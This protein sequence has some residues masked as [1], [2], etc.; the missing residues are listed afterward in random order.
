MILWNCNDSV[1]PARDARVLW[2]QFTCS[3][4]FRL[5]LIA[6]HITSV[7][8]NNLINKDGF[9]TSAPLWIDQNEVRVFDSDQSHV[10]APSKW[11]TLLDHSAMQTKCQTPLQSYHDVPKQTPLNLEGSK[12]MIPVDLDF[13]AAVFGDACAAAHWLKMSRAGLQVTPTLQLALPN[14]FISPPRETV[15]ARTELTD[16]QRMHTHKWLRRLGFSHP[17]WF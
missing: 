8:I 17:L 16:V 2:G 13:V 15:H 14:S 11:C 6:F 4:T 10:W 3:P 12:F 9:H 1:L 5:I 7:M